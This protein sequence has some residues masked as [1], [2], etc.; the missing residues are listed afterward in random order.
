MKVSCYLL[1]VFMLV[2][3]ARQSQAGVGQAGGLFLQI[4]PDARSTAMGETGVAHARNALVPAWNPGGLGFVENSGISG[5]YFKWLPYLADDLYYLHFSYV[6]PVEGI[7]TFGVSLPYLSLGEQERISATGDSQGTFNSSDMA[8][9]LSYGRRINELLGFG[10]NL[11]LVR[12]ALSDEDNGVG[13]SFALDFGLT[14]NV[15]PRFTVAGVVQNLGKDISYVNPDQGDPLYRNLKVGAAL[16]AL[17]TESNSLLLAVDLN[18]PLL[19]DAG[20]ILNLGAE[21]LYQ[22]FIALRAG[23]IHDAEGDV[24]T[25]TFGGGL[26][27]KMYRI[28]FSYTTGST[29]QDITKF[30][31]SAS[32]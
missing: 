19:E 25:P 10:S 8:V 20:N 27:W 4:A 16:K 13:S 32:F 21:F 3:P 26:K 2:I 15:L 9:T 1:I 12:S 14:A 24:K 30:T 22:D 18:R 5:T 6:H 23:Y 31:I 7:G 11:K 28:D 29:L 17:E